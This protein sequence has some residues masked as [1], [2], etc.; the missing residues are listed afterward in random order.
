MTV[1]T[2]QF[3]LGQGLSSRV[4][5]YWGQAYGGFSHVDA[6][7]PTGDSYEL[8]G[9]RSDRVGGKPPGLYPR[10]PE[11]ESW[12]RVERVKI[13]MTSVQYD[14]WVRWYRR[15]VGRPYDIGTI[16]GD[17]FG[18]ADHEPGRYIC[19]AAAYEAL[20]ACGKAHQAPYHPSQITPNALALMVSAGLGGAASMLAAPTRF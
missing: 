3:V 17:I 2:L 6:M 4:I 12:V 18:R 13:P 15:N 9:E 10:P 11:Y 19:S 1:A 16:W 5:A 7:I 20:H 14:A 8:Y